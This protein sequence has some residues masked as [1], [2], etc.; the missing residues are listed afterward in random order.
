VALAGKTLF[1]TNLQVFD[2]VLSV[3]VPSSVYPPPVYPEEANI[4]IISDF[5]SSI[6]LSLFAQDA[7]ASNL[8]TV[9]HRVTRRHRTL[10]L[11]FHLSNQDDKTCEVLALEM[12]FI[13]ITARRLH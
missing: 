1:P 9:S 6:T 3:I 10:S 8:S 4:Q 7:S 13:S 11:R 5:H 12:F 2:Q